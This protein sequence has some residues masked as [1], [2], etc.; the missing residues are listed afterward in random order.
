MAQSVI[1]VRLALRDLVL[2]TLFPDAA[3]TLG[4]PG[5]Y[6][7][8]E[9]V[10]LGQVRVPVGRP[11]AGTNRSRELAT[12]HDIVLS[13]ARL[14]GPEVQEEADTKALDMARLIEDYF[15]V[16]PQETLNDACREALV[17]D[18]VLDPDIAWEYVGDNEVVASGRTAT[19]TVTVTAYVRR[20]TIP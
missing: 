8:G 20:T 1:G 13:V 16:K 15:R 2:A 11:T 17:S 7:P 5:Q 6:E 4:P 18:I 9:V 3:T 19:A 10:T 12:E 14:G